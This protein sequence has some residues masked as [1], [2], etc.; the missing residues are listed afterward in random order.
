MT[1]IVTCAVIFII[2]PSLERNNSISL[3]FQFHM[4][5][6]IPGQRM[7]MRQVSYGSEIFSMNRI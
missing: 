7:Y 5:F 1:L 6:I 4:I 3:V 2:E